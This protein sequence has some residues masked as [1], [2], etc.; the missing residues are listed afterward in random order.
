MSILRVGAGT[1]WS[2]RPA[3][4]GGKAVRLHRP[5]R[6]NSHRA[7]IQNKRAARVLGTPVG[8]LLE[9]G[10]E[11]FVGDGTKDK[12]RVL[13]NEGD[14][15]RSLYAIRKDPD[16][17]ICL[18]QAPPSMVC[19]YLGIERKSIPLEEVIRRREER[20]AKK[21]MRREARRACL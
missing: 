14:L 4:G 9:D 18:L 19:E 12:W 7:K 1:G 11:T 2:Y 16:W 20:L 10:S 17:V 13:T 5:L 15:A 21:R 6:S 3:E 8:H